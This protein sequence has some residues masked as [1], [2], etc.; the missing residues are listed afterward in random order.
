MNKFLTH[1]LIFVGLFALISCNQKGSII[2]VSEKSTPREA[3]AVDKISKALIGE[4]YQVEHSDQ[5]NDN[6]ANKQIV[7][8]VART[9]P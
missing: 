4:G 6:S 9:C 3:F 2:V 8:P 5:I 7:R 1:I